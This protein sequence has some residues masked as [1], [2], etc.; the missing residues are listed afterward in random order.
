MRI[1]LGRIQSTVPFRRRLLLFN[2][3]PQ[4]LSWVGCVAAVILFGGLLIWWHGGDRAH[5]GVPLIGALAG[6]LPAV[7]LA[8]P[9]RFVV[10]GPGRA[11]AFQVLEERMLSGGFVHAGVEEGV[12]RYRRKQPRWLRWNE[13][14]VH[15]S[16]ERDVLLVD[17]PRVMLDL[18]RRALRYLFD[19]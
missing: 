9:S 7:W 18:H 5:F 8:R 4:F 15:L 2:S 3:V 13:Q 1:E 10:H 16:M 17:G 6:S 19:A 14:D 12:H 11:Q